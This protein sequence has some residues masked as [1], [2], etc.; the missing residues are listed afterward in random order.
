MRL[1][2]GLLRCRTIKAPLLRSASA[3]T[4]RARIA[5]LVWLLRQHSCAC[6][7]SLLETEPD[8]V[9][10]GTASGRAG[11]SAA[12]RWVFYGATGTAAAAGTDH[13]DGS[14]HLKCHANAV[15]QGSPGSASGPN[16]GAPPS[17]RAPLCRPHEESKLS[18]WAPLD[19]CCR[20]RRHATLVAAAAASAV[21]VW[22]ALHRRP[23]APVSHCLS[24]GKRC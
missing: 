3:M 19:F 22:L 8:A 15:G 10:A 14:K 7:C 2:S 5:A 18:M 23:R 6:L 13:G 16:S 12:C 9:R 24:G 17:S 4:P 1:V 20:C 11:A 21:V